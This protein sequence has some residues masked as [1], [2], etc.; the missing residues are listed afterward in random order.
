[1]ATTPPKELIESLKTLVLEVEA[2]VASNETPQ[3]LSAPAPASTTTE[4]S[5]EIKSDVRGYNGQCFSLPLL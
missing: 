4:K 5:E 2:A 1:M 3:P